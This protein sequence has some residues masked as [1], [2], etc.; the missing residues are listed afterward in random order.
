MYSVEELPTYFNNFTCDISA[1]N[2]IR[3][4]MCYIILEPWYT[5]L[6]KGCLIIG[7]LLGITVKAIYFSYLHHVANYIAKYKTESY[8]WLWSQ[9][10]LMALQASQLYLQ[11]KC[12]LQKFAVHVILK[13]NSYQWSLYLWDGLFP[14]LQKNVHCLLCICTFLHHPLIHLRICRVYEFAVH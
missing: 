13:R 10:S 12:R 2:A 4:I 6:L 1:G 9:S 7:S 3:V 14:L 5:M 11:E 8:M